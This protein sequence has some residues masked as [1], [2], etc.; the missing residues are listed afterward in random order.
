MNSADHEAEKGP[1]AA[2][3]GPDVTALV[4][5]A[6]VVGAGPAGSV[7]ALHLAERGR[8][9][10][11]LDK[12][13][14]PRD[15]VCGDALIPDALA[16][17]RRCGLFDAVRGQAHVSNTVS[18]YSPS[19]I[20][21]DLP[22]EF[23]TIRREILDKQIL[24]GAV[25]R[26]A[27]FY[28]AEVSGVESQRQ[29]IRIFLK[30]VVQPVQA[31]FGILA[32]GADVS[33]LAATGMLQRRQPSGVAVRCYVHSPWQ[34]DELIVSLDRAILPGYAWIFPLGGDVY[35][36]G[37]GGFYH[38][39]KN[40]RVN[41]REMFRAFLSRF[42]PARQLVERATDTTPLRGAM[43]RCG[44]DGAAAHDGK[45]FVAIGETIGTTF[46]FTGEGIGKAMETGE[47]AARQVDTA[48]ANGGPESL[49]ALPA[50]IERELAPRYTGYHV[51]ESWASRAWLVDMLAR[52]MQRSPAL[53]R[54]AAGIIAETIDPR[55]V[56]RW[57]NL[58]PRWLR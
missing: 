28:S 36:V 3:A 18:I 57:R 8:A 39:R 17:L 58:L 32:T 2:L 42:P 22:G 43:L 31:R 50:M 16:S 46:P 26:G 47:L 12:H 35:N 37:A 54:A 19:Q 1:S 4:W 34:I 33:L 48:L 15:K 9:V 10:L 27:R 30:G 21:V 49:A 51:A 20:R 53:Q 29:G 45:C 6:V 25:A 38:G 11:L 13:A 55:S 40:R 24:D 7:A 41:L 56:F 23:L 14:F 44:L 5:D 52:R